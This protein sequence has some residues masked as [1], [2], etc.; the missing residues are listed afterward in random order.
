[1]EE[2]AIPDTESLCHKPREKMGS[3]F[4]R[5]NVT[6]KKQDSASLAY[7]MSVTKKSHRAPIETTLG[8]R[9]KIALLV[10]EAEDIKCSRPCN[11]LVSANSLSHLC[12]CG[13][14]NLRWW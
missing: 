5:H 4:A 11:I 6:W 10:P 1:M 2:H 13:L 14:R 7:A 8:D 3:P 12:G 9:S